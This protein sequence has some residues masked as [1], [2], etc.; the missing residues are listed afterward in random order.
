MLL[1]VPAVG[2]EWSSTG[3]AVVET[4][5]GGSERGRAF[6]LQPVVTNEDWKPVVVR[7]CEQLIELGSDQD[8]GAGFVPI[9]T[10][11][12]VG[13]ASPIAPPTDTHLF[14]CSA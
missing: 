8:L 9:D 7:R 3:H 6:R 13:F 4:R 12:A 11:L 5:D 2:D 1:A 10:R 14:Q